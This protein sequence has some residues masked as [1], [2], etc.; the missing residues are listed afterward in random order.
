MTKDIKNFLRN[1]VTCQ[2]IKSM[3]SKP[4]GLLQPLPIPEA[5]WVDVTMDF[6]TGLPSVKYKTVIVVV[7]D[8]LSKYGHLG[9]LPANYTSTGVAGFF[10]S[11]IVR[12]HGV[13]RTI[14][15]DRDKVFQNRFWKELLSRSGTTLQMSTAYHSQTDGQSEI[16]IKAIEQY[17]RGMVHNISRQ[18]L[19]AL[20]WT[21]L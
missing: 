4:A 10:I 7:I 9:A 19:E 20:H 6:I 17:L 21:E 3:T 13:P 11:E 14:T 15:S 8:R 16:V 5:I 2:E 1:C 12:L 18:W